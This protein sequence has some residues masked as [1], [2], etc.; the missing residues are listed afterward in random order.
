MLEHII[1]WTGVI[2]CI[3][4]GVSLTAFALIGCAMLSNLA[5]NRLIESYGGWKVFLEY[6]DWYHEHKRV[7]AD[8]QEW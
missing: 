6:R 7:A 5:Q 1:Y 4:G 2:V 3:A 8:N